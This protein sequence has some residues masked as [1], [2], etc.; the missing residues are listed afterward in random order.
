MTH[1]ARLPIAATL[2]LLLCVATAAHAQGTAAR[3]PMKRPATPA[4]PAKLAPALPPRPMELAVQARALEEQGNYLAALGVLKTLRGLQA[5]DA[6][7]ELAI[8]LDEARTGLADSAWARL[9]T[10]LMNAA[11]ADTGGIG[12]RSEYPF[13]RE[14]LWVNGHFD[15]WYWYVARARAELALARRDWRE[16]MSMAS[17]AASARPLSGKE[18][19]L[20][21]IA[22]GH[23]GDAQL[24]EAAAAWAAYLE[25]WLPE[26]HYLSGLWAWRN[27][28][29][30]DARASLRT[31][32]ELDSSWRDPVL[33]LARLQLPAMPADSLPT[34]FL[35]GRRACALLTSAKRPKQ[36]EY[37]QFDAVPMLAFNPMTQP[38][39]SLRSQLHLKKPTQLFLQVLVS[40]RGVPLLVELPY[41][42]EAQVPAAIVNHIVS[43]V[44][45][46]RFI[47][48]RRFEKPQRS[49]ASVQYLLQP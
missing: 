25:P 16:A 22:A 21:A 4:A 2:A 1:C 49:W 38:P 32:A 31:A 15:G 26:A 6:D 5:P 17:R 40:E 19:L 13:Q 24:S 11:L 34:R 3:H 23:S 36:E 30:D 43:V 48:A 35:V 28:K 7:L 41:V 14:P 18:A 10:P 47:A 12:R 9:H 46:W 8:A 33:A 29:R 42:T 39:D 45:D 27:G 44:G 37:I 20:L